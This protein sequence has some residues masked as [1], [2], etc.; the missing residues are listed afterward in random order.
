MELILV[1]LDQGEGCEPVEPKVGPVGRW[2]AYLQVPKLR[3]FL[4]AV[5]Q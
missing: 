4:A 3:K 2:I 1:G 5:V